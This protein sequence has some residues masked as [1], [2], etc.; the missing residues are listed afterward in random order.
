MKNNLIF[1]ST[2]ICF[3]TCPFDSVILIFAS[4]LISVFPAIVLFVYNNLIQNINALSLACIWVFLYCFVLF[5]RKVVY[6]YHNHYYLNYKTLLRFEKKIKR[7]FFDICSDLSY[8]SYLYPEIVNQTRRAQ[9]ASINIFRLYQII[10]EI[11]ASVV[12]IIAIGTSVVTIDSSLV[13]FLVLTIISPIIDN[14][15]KIIQKKYLLYHNTQL[16]KED[17]E[18]SKLLT[19]S[20]FLKEIIELNAFSFIHNKWLNIQNKIIKEKAVS[21]KKITIVSFFMSV[22]RIAATSAAYCSVTKLFI[23]SQI[24]IAEFSMIIMTFSQITQIFNQIFSL[25]GNLTEF[26]IMVTPFFDFIRKI[27]VKK[28]KDEQECDNTIAL[29]NV[30]F[31]YPNSDDWALKDINLTIKEGELVSIVGENGSGKTTLANVLMGFLNPTEGTVSSFAYNNINGTIYDD[32]SLIPQDFNCYS[33]SIIDNIAFGAIIP[34]YEIS[35]MLKAVGMT[36]IQ[37]KLFD[38]YG[39]EF[40][41]IELSGGQKQKISI[42]RGMYKQC[43]L[44]ICDEPTSAIDPIQEG[45]INQQ[46]LNISKK[47]T[48][49]IVSHRLAL[50]KISD[51]IIVLSD[52]EIVEIGCHNDLLKQKGVYSKLWKSQSLLYKSD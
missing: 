12:G 45:I 2:K 32:L 46:L 51:K 25:F 48:T 4:V 14:V 36:E 41:G 24:N 42:L 28:V 40:G 21:E 47:N 26:T 23:D 15:Y 20:D 31:K 49:I 13:L 1:N 35:D 19:K 9:N 7:Q 39:L 5:A 18:F 22:V 16:E 30:S 6:N 29:N 17:Q 11:F 34:D 37:D 43:A 10:V 8:E 33:T 50:S 3:K 52:G 38:N 27:K 44:L